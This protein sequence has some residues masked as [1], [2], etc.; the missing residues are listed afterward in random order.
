MATGQFIATLAGD[1]WAAF[2]S[3]LWT[4]AIFRQKIITLIKKPSPN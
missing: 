4:V 1:L 3:L 2:L